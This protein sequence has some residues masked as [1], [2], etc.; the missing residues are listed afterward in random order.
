M[1]KCNFLTFGQGNLEKNSDLEG[2]SSEN[3]DE[4]TSW[5]DWNEESIRIMCLFCNYSN[6]EFICILT[7]MKEAHGFDFEETVKD[8]TFYQKV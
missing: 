3:E 5:S 8:L 6:N 7:H 1:Q 2:G 4:E